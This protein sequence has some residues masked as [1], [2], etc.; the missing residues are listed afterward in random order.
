[1]AHFQQIT[2]L[3]PVAD[4]N[5]STTFF[6]EVLGFEVR[7]QMDDYAYLQRDSVAIRLVQVAQGIDTHDP[8][9]ELSCYIDVEGLDELYEELKPNLDRLPD[10]RVRSPF[11]QAYGQ[12]EFHVIDEDSLLIFFGEPIMSDN[13]A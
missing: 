9:R 10:G 3:V 5:R 4:M 8:N 11:N 7:L 2:P 1:M 12:R 6:H 13:K